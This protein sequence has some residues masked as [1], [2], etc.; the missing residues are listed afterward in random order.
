[1]AALEA[2]LAA[3]KPMSDP[4]RKEQTKAHALLAICRQV[5][6]ESPNLIETILQTG[7]QRITVS[8]RQ[9]I[10]MERIWS[11]AVGMVIGL[12]LAAA[13]NAIGMLFFLLITK[14]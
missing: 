3:A 2:S 1:L 7:D 10:R 11:G 13:L 4:S 9:Y 14:S 8:L 5:A 12:V 6:P